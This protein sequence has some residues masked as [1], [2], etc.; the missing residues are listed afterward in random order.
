MSACATRA[1]GGH[2]Q[3]RLAP[4]RHDEAAA[5]AEAGL[6][7]ERVYELDDLVGG[8][9]LFA[10]TGVTGGPLL[11]GPWSRDGREWTESIVIAAGAVRRSVKAHSD[12]GREERA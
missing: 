5:L 8:H 6:D 11:R 1:L 9:S 4:Q 10:A 12:G 3:A 7:T 2:M